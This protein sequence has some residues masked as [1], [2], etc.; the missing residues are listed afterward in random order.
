MS[1][2]VCNDGAF[3]AFIIEYMSVQSI[4]DYPYLDYPNLD[5]PN[6]KLGSF[7]LFQTDV[8]L[9]LLFSLKPK[10]M[11]KMRLLAIFKVLN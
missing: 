7:F 6:T 10:K 1:V 8:L 11:A 5:Y 3:M 9:R 2:R 4:L